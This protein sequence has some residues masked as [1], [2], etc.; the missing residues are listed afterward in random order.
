YKTRVMAR[1]NLIVSVVGAITPDEVKARLDQLFGALPKQ[2]DLKEIPTVIP[3]IGQSRAIDLPQPQTRFQF[4][5]VG[6]KREDPDFIAAF[7]VNHILGG[8]GLTSRLS[9]E[10]REKRGLAYGVSTGLSNNDF[11]TVFGG[12]VST[13]ADFADKTLDVLMAE[14][15]RMGEEGPTQE[16]LDLAKSYVLGSY[17]LNFD[18]S[19]GTARALLGLQLQGREPS[20]IED[21]KAIINGV[22]LEDAKRAAR[23]LIGDADFTILRV[24]P[25]AG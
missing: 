7:L 17:A 22:T 19:R 3:R 10:I 24:G 18:G 21:R 12:S 9:N 11:S 20:Y 8:S 25:A 13:R 23:R 16:E 14:L 1:D 6:I 15:K 5:G 2:A 4:I